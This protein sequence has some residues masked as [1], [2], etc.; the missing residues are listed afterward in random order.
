MIKKTTKLYVIILIL[1][2]SIC[3]VSCV[4]QDTS[5][6]TV[7]L[8]I[9]DSDNNE[10]A[11]YERTVSLAT[12]AELLTFLVEEENSS[13]GYSASNSPAGIFINDITVSVDEQTWQATGLFP[14]ASKNEFCA[15]YH[16]LD[17]IKYIFIS[18]GVTPLLYNNIEFNSSGT[19]ASSTPLVDGES[20]L[21]TIKTY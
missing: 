17:D 19:G 18:D 14:D 16:T 10:L 8:Y 13:F 21:Y 20:Y 4:E 3:L 11:K 7:T 5:P 15:F 2:L 9:I 12:V 6:K 1:I